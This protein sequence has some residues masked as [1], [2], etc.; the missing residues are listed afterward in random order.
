[1]TLKFSPALA[2]RRILSTKAYY[3]NEF[4]CYYLSNLVLDRTLFVSCGSDYLLDSFKDK[5]TEELILDV[6][7]IYS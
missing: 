7:E 4:N 5:V 6:N 2:A 3:Q 1:M